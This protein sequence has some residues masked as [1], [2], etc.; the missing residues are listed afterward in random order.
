MRVEPDGPRASPDGSDRTTGVLNRGI[1][2][3]RAARGFEPPRG[4][5]NVVV[6]ERDDGRLG[7]AKARVER[8]GF[9]LAWLEEVAERHG[10]AAHA[11]RH[12][13]ARIIRGV[14]VDD[15]HVPPET[16]RMRAREAVERFR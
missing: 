16:G 13:R 3:Q 11:I 15:E 14:V 5:T 6:G 12:N 10:I 4:H 2:Q 8:A 1:R 7:R 9:S